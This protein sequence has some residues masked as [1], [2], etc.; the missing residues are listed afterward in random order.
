[1]NKV[2]IPADKYNDMLDTMRVNI[3]NDNV[4]IMLEETSKDEK[5]L[6]GYIFDSLVYRYKIAREALSREQMRTLSNMDPDSAKRI[7]NRDVMRFI[8]ILNEAIGEHD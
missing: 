3:V 6:K 5:H 7:E 2:T 8:E 4:D 1:M